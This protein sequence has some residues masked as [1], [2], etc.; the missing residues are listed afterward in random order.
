MLKCFLQQYSNTT[1]HSCVQTRRYLLKSDGV[2]WGLVY[3]LVAFICVCCCGG[4]DAELCMLQNPSII[5]PVCARERLE[6]W[7][8]ASNSAELCPSWCGHR[9]AV[10]KLVNVGLCHH[11]SPEKVRVSCLSAAKLVWTL[12]TEST[13]LV[14]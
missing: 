10:K 7:S 9:N 6:C 4:G 12:S 1:W 5:C 13:R 8:P 3:I 14:N 2:T 11:R